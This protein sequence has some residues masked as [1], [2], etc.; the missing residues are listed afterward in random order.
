MLQLCQSPWDKGL[1]PSPPLGL[2]GHSCQSVGKKSH[3]LAPY[4]QPPVSAWP[5]LPPAPPS[6]SLA[7][8]ALGFSDWRVALTLKL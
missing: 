4:L 1:W 2:H 7:T 6:C 5:R 8:L 3:R